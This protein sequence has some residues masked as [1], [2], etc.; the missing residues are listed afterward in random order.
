[1]HT[2]LLYTVMLISTGAIHLIFE[3]GA[4]KVTVHVP[5]GAQQ[6]GPLPLV[7]KLW[8]AL[9]SGL[10]TGCMIRIKYFGIFWKLTA[11]SVHSS[12]TQVSSVCALLTPHTDI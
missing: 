9:S 3:L 12:H 2:A 5:T 8:P 7:E 11:P 4:L 10:I 1:M 6:E